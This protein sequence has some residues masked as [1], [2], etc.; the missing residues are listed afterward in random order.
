[1]SAIAEILYHLHYRVQGSDLYLNNNIERLKRL[2]IEVYI[3]H[4]AN[5]I[6]CANTVIYSSAI[7]SDNVELVA[8]RKANKVI[9][10]RSEILAKLMEDKYVIAVSGSS[11]KTTTT[12][13][14]ASILDCAGVDATVI[15]GGILN[16]Y[17]SNAK[18]GNDNVFLIE[19][20]E[21]D[22]TMLRIPADIAVI[23]SV[24][25]EHI[26]YYG[27]SDNIKH[28][29]CQFIGKAEY[30]ILPD[31][32]NI[33]YFGDNLTT[34]GL[35]NADVKA[36]NIR[37][38]N[39]SLEF[40]ILVPAQGKNMENVVLLNALG[41]HKISNALAAISAA[42]RFGINEEN[43]RKGLQ[44]F[45]G[46]ER[47]FSLIDEINGIK[48]IE[49]YAGHPDQINAVLSTARSITNKKVLGV[50]GLSRFIRVR[51]FF[52]EYIKVFKL[53]DYV[54]LIPIY[55]QEDQVILGYDIYNIQRIL[56][57]NGFNNV[58]IMNDSL[59][60]SSFISDF[61]NSGDIILFIGGG[62]NIAKL[63]KE[64]YARMK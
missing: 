63:A 49:D 3:G 4:N 2:G 9:M 50:I 22:G 24:N 8:A 58:K 55:P 7:R 5:N 30:A 28:A 56:M 15:V 59:L 51:N 29:F 19:A 27:T 44:E 42:I 35:Q 39:N 20:D 46:V 36:M 47:R 53:F 6:D 32:V 1:M 13:M 11:G 18:F 16:A 52:N 64:V 12:A 48:L 21:S 31:S 57:H 34:F 45:K 17:K 62:S 14:I 54:I 61:A 26:D 38:Y 40:D 60:I 43:I 25:D 41:M 33:G 10:R 23:T 37:Q